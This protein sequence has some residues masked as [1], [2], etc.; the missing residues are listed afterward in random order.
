MV[1]KILRK[2]GTSREKQ[3]NGGG[4]GGEGANFIPSP[5]SVTIDLNSEVEIELN[6]QY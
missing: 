3:Q 5:Q 4:E 2:F 1:G 6:C